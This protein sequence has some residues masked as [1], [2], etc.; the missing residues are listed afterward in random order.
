[1]TLRERLLG[2]LVGGRLVLQPP[3]RQPAAALRARLRGAALDAARRAAQAAGR[4]WRLWPCAPFVVWNLALARQVQRGD[5]PAR[6]YRRLPRLA[7]NAARVVSEAVGFPTTWPASWLFALRE[8][9]PP[10]RYDLLV[11]RYLFYRQNNLGGA[12]RA[13]HEGDEALLGEG[14]GEVEERFDTK[15]RSTNGSA[16]VFAPLD[17]PEAL[18]VVVTAAAPREGTEVR[19]SVNGRPVGR[20]AATRAL[21][22]HTVAVGPEVWR[23]ELNSVRLD[24]GALRV[25]VDHIRFVRTPS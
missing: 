18:S 24:A 15:G 25:F 2:R 16:R 12:D 23:R 4:G 1:M 5:C 3:L 8:G 17:V 9:R 6:R 14:W 20:F 10:G 13:R 21:R 7:G 22:E 19:L 11:G